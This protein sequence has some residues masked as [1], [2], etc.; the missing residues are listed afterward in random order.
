MTVLGAL[1]RWPSRAAALAVL[2]VL[3]AWL[4]AGLVAPYLTYLEGLN[5]R[6]TAQAAIFARMAALAATPEAPVP[7]PEPAAL[8]LPDGSDAQ[9]LADL[10]DRL[11]RIASGNGLE[12]QGI[13]VLPRSETQVVARLGVRLR[14]TGDM[15]ALNRFVHAVESATPALSV[16]NLRIQSRAQRG[17][18]AAAAPPLDLQL[19]VVGFRMTGS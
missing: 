14:G 3:A 1:G 13:Q 8:L 4:H 18:S 19:D 17:P 6:V 2:A 15:A 16:D 11:K 7:S 12:V 5:D 9:A 10:Q